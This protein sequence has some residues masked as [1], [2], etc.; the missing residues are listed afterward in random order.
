MEEE[1]KDED[2][3]QFMNSNRS[4]RRQKQVFNLKATDLHLTLLFVTRNAVLLTSDSTAEG[5]KES[6]VFSENNQTTFN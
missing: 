6:K 5:D 3:D 4:G 2:L 1:K